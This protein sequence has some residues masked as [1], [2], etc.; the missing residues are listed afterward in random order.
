MKSNKQIIDVLNRLLH[1]QKFH[2]DELLKSLYLV[3]A[4][5]EMMG[6][7]DL[8]CG[9]VDIDS[10]DLEIIRFIQSRMDA[11]EVERV[12]MFDPIQYQQS[13]IYLAPIHNGKKNEYY[14]FSL[15]NEKENRYLLQMTIMMAELL[16]TKLVTYRSVESDFLVSDIQRQL[17]ENFSDGYMTINRDGIVMYINQTGAKILDI[18]VNQITGSEIDRFLDFPINILEPLK[19]HKGLINQD[20]YVKAP[21]GRL[22]LNVTVVP[23]LSDYE[24]GLGILIIFNEVKNVRKKL[25]DLVGANATFHFNQILHKSPEMSRVIRLAQMSAQNESNILIESESGTGKEMLAQAIH[26]HSNRKGGP[27]IAIDCSAIPRELVESELFG[28]VE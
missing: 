1:N 24:E 22:Y 13:W 16:S 26:N 18:K 11:L 17:C 28:Y 12:T 7:F 14:I 10:V 6:K 21:K 15:T 27:F 20:L 2:Y 9:E 25:N 3:G 5:G 23:L 4:D 19:T 8:Q